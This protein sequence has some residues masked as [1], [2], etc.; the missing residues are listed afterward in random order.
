[1]L[2]AEEWVMEVK[3]H[4]KVKDVQTTGGLSHSEH[5]KDK[6]QLG[7]ENLTWSE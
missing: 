6:L 4:A 2:E 5:H 7:L 1:V 3:V